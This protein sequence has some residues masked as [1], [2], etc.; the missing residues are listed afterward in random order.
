MISPVDATERLI[1]HLIRILIHKLLARGAQPRAIGG[2]QALL[3]AR[4]GIGRNADRISR[5]SNEE[6]G[7]QNLRAD[8][9]R[10]KRI[11]KGWF[12]VRLSQVRRATMGALIVLGFASFVPV[13]SLGASDDTMSADAKLRHLRSATEITLLIVP[14]DVEFHHQVDKTL[15]QRVSCVYKFA[16]DQGAAFDKLF[17]VMRHADIH[18][19]DALTHSD[20]RVGLIFGRS[21]E[22]LSEFYF[23]RLGRS[24]QSEWI[25]GWQ[26]NGCVRRLAKPTT[27]ARPTP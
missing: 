14:F 7:C 22:V 5:S 27:C 17:D 25:L 21:G 15:L 11:P 18:G 23:G 1:A 3:E 2:G 9:S 6:I 24:L 13:E 8:T 19:V 20:L 4:C 12:V 16:S 10:E 26:L